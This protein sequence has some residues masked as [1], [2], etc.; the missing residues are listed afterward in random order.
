MSP[1]PLRLVA[2]LLAFAVG[3]GESTQVGP[4]E[5]RNAKEKQRMEARAKGEDADNDGR[6]W[7]GWRYTG[8]RQDCFFVVGRK[9]FKTEQA[10]CAA[11][12]CGAGKRCATDGAGPATVSCAKK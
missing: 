11:A 5:P 3:C 4:N 8:D 10:A 7:G 2:A 6:K 1:R 9:C 12:K